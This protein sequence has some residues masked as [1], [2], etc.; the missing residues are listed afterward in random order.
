ML[1]AD[2]LVSSCGLAMALLGRGPQL[3]IGSERFGSQKSIGVWCQVWGLAWMV[4]HV[5][6]RVSTALDKIDAKKGFD[7]LIV[8]IS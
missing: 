2:V 4:E 6:L 5:G 8:N 1:L 3:F 7:E